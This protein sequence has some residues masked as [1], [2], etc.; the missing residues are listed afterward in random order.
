[1]KWL[2]P[3]AE[4]WP[5]ASMVKVVVTTIPPEEASAMKRD[6]SVVGS[7]RAKHVFPLVRME[8]REEM[9]LSHI[10]DATGLS[11]TTPSS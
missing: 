7:D 6:L 5:S 4:W 1:M 8:D 10:A 11:G 3:Y 2:C 9:T